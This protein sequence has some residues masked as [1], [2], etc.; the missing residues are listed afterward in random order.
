MIQLNGV[1]INPSKV[2]YNG[3]ELSELKFNDIVVWPEKE[4]FFDSIT[5]TTVGTYTDN[6]IYFKKIS[7]NSG[8]RSVTYELGKDNSKSYPYYLVVCV[9]EFDRDMEIE[10]VGITVIKRTDTLPSEETIFESNNNLLP[11][12][13]IDSHFTEYDDCFMIDVSPWVGNECHYIRSVSNDIKNIKI[14]EC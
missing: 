13:K 6:K 14:E 9:N 5:N 3:I 1:S 7:A 4:S 10:T 8:Y 11:N 12:K 2:I